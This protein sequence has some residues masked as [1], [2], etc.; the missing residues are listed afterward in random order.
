MTETLLSPARTAER[1][2]YPALAAEIAALLEDPAVQVPARLVQALPGGGSLFVMPALD[3]RLAI[4][5]LITFTPANAGTGRP[6]IQGDV[7]VFDIATGERRL[8]LDGPT[9]TARRTAAV[10]LLAAQTLAP[11]PDGPLLIVGAGV[12][13]KAHL[14]A[15]TAGLGVKE[16]F[17][18][19]R[20]TASAEALAAHARTL[21]LQAEVIANP[22]AALAE[23][24]LVV[25]CTPASGVVLRTEPRPDA[26]IAAVGAFTPRMVELAPELCRHLAELG[27]VVVDTRD[28]DHE[29]GDLLQARLDVSRFASLQ[30]VLQAK[31]NRPPGPVLFKS[32]GWAGW[33]LA[34]ARLALPA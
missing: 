19:S 33:D 24:P 7:V 1:L 8:V 13:G 31:K 5:K 30:D 6:A 11:N 17:I 27:T 9:V 28:A 14:E 22:N 20:S 21:G 34:A 32:C 18:A 4:T 26:F 10:S 25:T 23:A 2:P 16:V 12:Q 3:G 15:F 29:A